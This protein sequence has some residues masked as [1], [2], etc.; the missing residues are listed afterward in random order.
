[1]TA[2]IYGLSFDM[3][4]KEEP[5]PDNPNA[6]LYESDCWNTTLSLRVESGL[7]RKEF[8][9]AYLEQQAENSAS[10]MGSDSASWLLSIFQS[11]F[12]SMLLWQPLT[13]YVIAWIKIW[14]FTWHLKMEL[15]PGNIIALFKRCCC[16]S[17]STDNVA[18]TPDEN[19]LSQHLTPPETEQ[20]S[21]YSLKGYQTYRPTK[22]VFHDDR[23]FDLISF[24]G[25]STW[26]IDD[27]EDSLE[28]EMDSESAEHEGGVE[29]Q[30]ITT[31]GGPVE[32]TNDE[33]HESG[34]IDVMDN[35]YAMISLIDGRSISKVNTLRSIDSDVMDALVDA[36]IE[37][38][39]ETGEIE[40]PMDKPQHRAIDSDAMI[41][42]IDAMMRDDHEDDNNIGS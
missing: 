13:A 33:T 19:M 9:D 26:M 34:E 39:N 37:E 6:A 17:E 14:L 4:A 21:I 18:M 2:I 40:T 32:N 20:P 12:Q 31:Q 25:N 16:K 5:N 22:V 8:I 36:V 1:M 30:T 11:L 15:G 7:S 24:L 41:S 42:L 10:Y 35:P 3:E 23:P 27:L 38:D 28:N 29:L